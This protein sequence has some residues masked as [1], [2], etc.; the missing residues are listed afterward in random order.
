MEVFQCCGPVGSCLSFVLWSLAIK[1]RLSERDPTLPG[2]LCE[3]RFTSHEEADGQSLD[4]A[5]R[6]PARG[7]NSAKVP[8]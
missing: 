6:E 4:T 8:T 5:T 7:L 1:L 2:C 3:R